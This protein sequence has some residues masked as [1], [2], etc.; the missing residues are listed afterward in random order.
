MCKFAIRK[1]P[2]IMEMKTAKLQTLERFP[3][4]GND[5]RYQ[6]HAPSKNE[7]MTNDGNVWTVYDNLETTRVYTVVFDSMG[8]NNIYDDRV[9]RVI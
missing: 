6:W 5:F 3:K 4:M 8:N 1:N 9:V 7:L 2:K